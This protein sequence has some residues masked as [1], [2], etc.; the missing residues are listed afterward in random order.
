MTRTRWLQF[1]AFL[2]VTTSA[3]ADDAI[4]ELPGDTGAFSRSNDV[5]C[6]RVLRRRFR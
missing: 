4:V 5:G 3:W 2:L 6:D 1:A